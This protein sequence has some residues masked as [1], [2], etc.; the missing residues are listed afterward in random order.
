M[1]YQCRL[2]MRGYVRTDPIDLSVDQVMA[3]Q[4]HAI[5]QLLAYRETICLWRFC[6]AG[7]HG[8]VWDQHKYVLVVNDLRDRLP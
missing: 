4:Y 1:T 3:R 7:M 6:L 2:T 8:R 5:V